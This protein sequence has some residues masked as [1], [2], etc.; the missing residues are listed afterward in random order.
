MAFDDEDHCGN[1]TS[2]GND[3]LDCIHRI[4]QFRV[5]TG[6][7]CRFDDSHVA[8]NHALGCVRLDNRYVPWTSFDRIAIHPDQQ[9]A[10]ANLAQI[11]DLRSIEIR[12]G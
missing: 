3:L 11:S 9:V 12:R 2:L 4:E 8:T 1:R 7:T 6:G 10:L 5:G